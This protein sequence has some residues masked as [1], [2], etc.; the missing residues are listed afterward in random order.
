MQ[1]GALSRRYIRWRAHTI[2]SEQPAK[3]EPAKPHHPLS[4]SRI[5]PSKTRHIS[6][7]TATHLFHFVPN[8]RSDHTTQQWL[9]KL[10]KVWKILSCHR[11][12]QGLLSVWCKRTFR[13]SHGASG[14]W[15]TLNASVKSW[16]ARFFPSVDHLKSIF[17]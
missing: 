16:F 15:T 6:K 11:T 4:S 9:T 12:L 7:P 8:C 10:L 2:D 14:R 13:S 5:S 3:P 17:Q 1:A